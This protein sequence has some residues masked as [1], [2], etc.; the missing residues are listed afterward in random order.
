M[1]MHHGPLQSSLLPHFISLL[2]ATNYTYIMTLNV[3]TTLSMHPNLFLL[4][5]RKRTSISMSKRSRPYGASRYHS[6]RPPKLTTSSPCVVLESCL[7]HATHFSF[8][9]PDV[10]RPPS[11]VAIIIIP[12]SGLALLLPRKAD[13]HYNYNLSS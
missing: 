13:N 10:H 12:V 3:S 2:I 1:F 6:G 5:P 4:T 8:F 11:T 9:A 7:G